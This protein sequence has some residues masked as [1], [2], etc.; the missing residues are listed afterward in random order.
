MNVVDKSTN[1]SE[2]NQSTLDKLNKMIDELGPLIPQAVKNII[3][4]SKEY[5]SRICNVPSNTTLL[6][7]RLYIDLYDKEVHVNLDISPYIDFHSLINMKPWK[8]GKTICVI[9]VFS[10]L[11]MQFANIVVAFLSRG[12]TVTKIA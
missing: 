1:T 8:F 4:V 5:E 10:F 6:L 7:E 12:S 9:L 2:Q 3:H 11:F